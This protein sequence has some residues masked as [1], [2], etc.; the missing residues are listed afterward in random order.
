MPTVGCLTHFSQKHFRNLTPD[1]AV[2]FPEVPMSVSKQDRSD[3]EQGRAD[4]DQGVIEKTF[5]DVIVNHPDSAAYY[6]GREGEQLDGDK[7][8]K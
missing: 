8:D 7:K 4:R 1:P 6:K 5:N 3:Y 2:N